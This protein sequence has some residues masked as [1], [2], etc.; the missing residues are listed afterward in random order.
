[1]T[2][3][4]SPPPPAPPNAPPAL[5]PMPPPPLP[6]PPPTL[7]PPP[8]PPPPLSPIELPQHGVQIV[9]GATGEFLACATD[10]NTATITVEAPVK[11]Y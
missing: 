6:P 1:M 8:S 10:E 11:G 5:P 9:D 2:C 7:P 4:P 3:P